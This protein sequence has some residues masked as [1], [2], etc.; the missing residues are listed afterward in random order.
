[1]VR[2][3]APA[4]HVAPWGATSLL[5]A[6]WRPKLLFCRSRLTSQP[7]P[8]QA[9]QPVSPSPVC[10]KADD[11]S[12]LSTISTFC[13]QTLP[14]D[15]PYAS[16]GFQHRFSCIVPTTFSFFLHPQ[17]VSPQTTFRPFHLGTLRSDLDS[18]GLLEQSTTS[19]TIRTGR[20]TSSARNIRLPLDLY[21]SRYP[22]GSRRTPTCYPCSSRTLPFPPRHETTLF[23]HQPLTFERT[24]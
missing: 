1:V 22:D 10:L 4:T 23:S 16:S 9:P 7:A 2:A 13:H 14:N 18:A 3:P 5:A 21:T 12:S 11:T 8:R 15:F 24:S 19:T 17:L 6:F 20:T